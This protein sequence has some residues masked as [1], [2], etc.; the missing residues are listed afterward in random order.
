MKKTLLITASAAAAL[1][2]CQNGQEAQAP[3]S[4][5]ASA[6]KPA[7]SITRTPTKNAYFGDTHVHTKNSFDAFIVG[8]RTTADDA[9]RFAKGEAIDNGQGHPIK[10]DGPPL[11]F[12]SVTDH[13]EYMGVI[14]AMRDK[15]NPISKTE[16]AKSIFGLFGGS[17]QDRMDAFMRIGITIVTG[18]PIEDI[19]DREF[20]DSAWAENVAATEKHNQPGVFTTFAGYEFTNMSIIGGVDDNLG[21]LNLHRNVIFE[22]DAPERLFTTLVSTNPEDLWAWMNEERA[23]GRDVLA[24]PHNSNGSNGKMFDTVMNDG[25]PMTAAYAKNRVLNEPIVEVTQIKGTSET[26]PMLSPS[27][28]F[29]NFELYDILIG[30]PVKSKISTGSFVRP[31]LARGLA[32]EAEIGANPY[33]FGMIGASDTHVSGPS[34]SEENHFGKFAS[35]LDP[36]V[37]A[38]IPPEGETEWPKDFKDSDELTIIAASQYGA[39][40]LAGVWAESNTREDIFSAMRRKETFATSGPRLRVRMFAGHDYPDGILSQPDMLE[41]A[42]AGG[43]PMGGD[44]EGKDSSPD[45]LVWA[46]QDPAGIP[47]QRLQMIKVWQEGGEGKETIFDVACAR[48]AA[49][50][51]ATQRCPDNGAR[52]DLATCGTNNSTGASELKSVWQDPDYNSAQK[53]AYYVRVLENPKCRWSTWDAIRN[54][55]PPNPSMQATLQDR[56]WSS[57]IWVKASQK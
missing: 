2:G 1:L 7:A 5:A 21:A 8:T 6:P 37:R 19:Y 33:Q 48:G 47:L 41:A 11:D 38:S 40:G 14:A 57:P 3:Q 13:G 4:P 56:A 52:V 30:M 51:P 26:H 32:I 24:I 55:T 15:D 9:Y 43:V 23:A 50:D 39:S 28:E 31:S 49:V 36:H 54:G 29:A 25:S 17:R 18:E 44:I 20:I 46:T 45:F 22:D 16:T 10:L 35:D 27:D 12:Y 34:L 42:Y 53:A